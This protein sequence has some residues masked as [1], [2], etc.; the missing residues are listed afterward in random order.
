MSLPVLLG[1]KDNKYYI[2]GEQEIN[3]SNLQISHYQELQ[4]DETPHDPDYLHPDVNKE[5]FNEPLQFD[6]SRL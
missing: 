6:N 3:G 5:G 2:N 1:S 4:N